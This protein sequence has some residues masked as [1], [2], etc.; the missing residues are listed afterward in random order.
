[1]TED[2][3]ILRELKREGEEI[4]FS[5][6]KKRMMLLSEGWDSSRA[7]MMETISQKY[8]V[9]TRQKFQEFKEKYNLTDY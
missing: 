8:G 1:M 6:E 9:D 3:E 7:K 4:I 2:Y 5:V